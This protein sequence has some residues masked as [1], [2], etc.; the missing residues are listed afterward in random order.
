MST[1]INGPCQSTERSL[2]LG[3]CPTCARGTTIM[4]SY[5]GLNSGNGLDRPSACDAVAVRRRYGAGAESLL[6]ATPGGVE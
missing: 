4:A 6:A 1:H 2:G 3:D 5:K